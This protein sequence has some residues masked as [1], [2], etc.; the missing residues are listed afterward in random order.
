MILDDLSHA[1]SSPALNIKVQTELDI[2]EK[3]KKGSGGPSHSCTQKGIL[4][5]RPRHHRPEVS[6]SC[7]QGQC[8]A[9]GIFINKNVDPVVSGLL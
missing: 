6:D 3:T 1:F 7:L 4:V 9:D 2:R 5:R 8:W